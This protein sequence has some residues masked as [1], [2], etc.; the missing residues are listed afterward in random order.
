MIIRKYNA[1]TGKISEVNIDI[2]AEHTAWEAHERTRPM[3]ESEVSRLIIAQQINSITVD[4]N[5]ALRMVEF[6]PAWETGIDYTA[7][8]KVQRG[9]TLYRCLTAHASQADWT[10]EAAPS[11]WAKVLI[12]DPDVIPEWE[13][14]DSTNP[15]MAGDKVQHNGK[16]WVSDV[17]NNVW[18]PGV[19]GWTEVSGAR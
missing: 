18:T 15:Y 5:T 1:D 13:Q 8:F 12:P 4:D 19:F 16:T 9:G 6:Y 2:Y 3:T 7:G 14:P 11:L 10:P 17:D